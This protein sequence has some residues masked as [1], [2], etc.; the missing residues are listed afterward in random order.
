MCEGAGGGG[1][2]C[3]HGEQLWLYAPARSHEE[4]SRGLCGGIGEGVGGGGCRY[5]QDGCSSL[6]THNELGR[7]T[8]PRGVC[9]GVVGGRRRCERGEQQWLHTTVLGR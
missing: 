2:R 8:W 1:R 3:E 4:W 7:T 9:E 6:D 5:G